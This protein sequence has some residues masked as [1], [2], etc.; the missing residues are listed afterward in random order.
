MGFTTILEKVKG[1]LTVCERRLKLDVLLFQ[2]RLGKVKVGV[3]ILSKD[4]SGRHY[5]LGEG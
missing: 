2:R 4:K 5:Y 1:M 3:N